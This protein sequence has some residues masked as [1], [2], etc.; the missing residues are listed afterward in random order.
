VF[1]ALATALHHPPAKAAQMLQDLTGRVIARAKE[2][3]EEISVRHAIRRLDSRL[4]R[5][6]L[7]AKDLPT[8]TAN[9]SREIAAVDPSAI[10]LEMKQRLEKSILDRDLLTLLSAYDN[11]GLFA[12]AASILGL[13]HKN[14]LQDLV[15]RLL[16]GPNGKV[17]RDALTEAMPKVIAP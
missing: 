8:L 6:D 2:N 9:Y 15:S 10:Y 1:V 14:D 11:K 4:K 17:L 3:L 5:V 7:T 13:R 16:S 12:D